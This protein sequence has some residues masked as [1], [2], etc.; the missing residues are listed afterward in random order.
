MAGEADLSK[1]LAGML[2]VLDPEAYVFATTKDPQALAHLP[3]IMRF[4]EREGE[5]L[6]LAAPHAAS[7]ALQKSEPY[8]RITLSVHSALEAVGFLAAICSALADKGICTNAVAVYY[9]D[10]IFV[11]QSRAHDAMVILQDLSAA[12]KR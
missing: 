10:H 1:L 6:I 9:H 2:P 3:A 5:T 7:A 8:A 12:T 11:P 4:T